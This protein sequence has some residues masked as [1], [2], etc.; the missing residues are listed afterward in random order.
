MLPSSRRRQH[1]TG[2]L[3]TDDSTPKFTPSPRSSHSSDGLPMTDD[4]DSYELRTIRPPNEPVANDGEEEDEGFL[5]STRRA[6]TDSA[7]SYELYTPDED[8]SVLKRLDRRLVCFMALLYCLSFL[9]R[10]SE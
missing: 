3:N 6:S 8:R 5:P 1:G 7:Q 10:S 9:D 2:S 4:P